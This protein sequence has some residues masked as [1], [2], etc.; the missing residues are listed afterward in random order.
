MFYMF[1]ICFYRF[2]IG[3]IGSTQVF[4]G[5]IQVSVFDHLWRRKSYQAPL[6]SD[7]I[8][9]CISFRETRQIGKEF[10]ITRI[11]CTFGPGFRFPDLWSRFH[12]RHYTQNPNF[13]SDFFMF[14]FQHRNIRK[15]EKQN[16][17]FAEDNSSPRA[18]IQTKLGGKS[19]Y[20]PPELP[21][22]LRDLGNQ[23]SSNTYFLETIK[24]IKHRY[25]LPVYSVERAYIAPLQGLYML[26]V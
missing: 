20:K 19:S 1:C 13:K 4:I 5:F 11:V 8:S 21:I 3:F 2:Y 24:N 17:Q 6:L 26:K 14:D 9:D 10:C 23:K 22:Q 16:K 15:S 7:R 12:G 18:R 25:L